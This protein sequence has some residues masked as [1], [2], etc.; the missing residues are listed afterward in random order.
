MASYFAFDHVG[1]AAQAGLI[2]NKSLAE[3]CQ[4]ISTYSWLLGSLSTVL[5]EVTGDILCVLLA[6]AFIFCDARRGYRR[7]Y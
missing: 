6:D 5:I 7:Q 4:K 1:W 3:R 2:K